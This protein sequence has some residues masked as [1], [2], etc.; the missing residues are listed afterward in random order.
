MP[1]FNISS[2]L[3]SYPPGL[4]DKDAALV[5]PLYR[6][7]NSLAQFISAN[8]GEIEYSPSEQAQANQLTKLLDGRTSKIFVRAAEALDY[9]SLLALSISS[10]K[11]VAHKANATNL[12]RPAL[13]V[14]DQLGGIALNGFG[15]AIFMQGRTAGISGTTFGAAYYLSTNGQIQLTPPVATGVLAQIVGV[16]LGSEGFYLNV[17]PVGRRPTLVYKFSPTVLRVLYSDGTFVDNAV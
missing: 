3:P 4:T 16:G 13:A 17:E 11:I 5:L 8:S 1:K 6:A 14:C 12:S 9:G 15:E 2:G 7:A 10:G